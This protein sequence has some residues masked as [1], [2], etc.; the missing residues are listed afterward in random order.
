MAVNFWC[1][2]RESNPRLKLG[3]L[4]CCHYT[5]PA[6]KVFVFYTLCRRLSSGKEYFFRL[7]FTPFGRIPF[8]MYKQEKYNG[9]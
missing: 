2:R 5:T 3:K 9:K 1:G 8:R 4:S 7:I 6:D